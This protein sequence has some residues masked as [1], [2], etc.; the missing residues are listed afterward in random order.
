MTDQ[1][2]RPAVAGRRLHLMVADTPSRDRELG[3]ISNWTAE[4]IESA[5]IRLRALFP[6]FFTEPPPRFL[7][8]VPKE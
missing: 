4:E 5:D 7:R 2:E 3:D 6:E 8:A 1:P